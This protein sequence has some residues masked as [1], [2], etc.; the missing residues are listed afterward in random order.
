MTESSADSAVV[1]PAARQS[2]LGS[3]AGRDLP[4]AD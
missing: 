3:T 1:G 4:S 2:D